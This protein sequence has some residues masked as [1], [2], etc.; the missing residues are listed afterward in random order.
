MTPDTGALVVSLD[1][2]LHWGVRDH[3]P[4]DGPYRANLLGARTAIPR[5]LDL[6]EE[7]GVSATWAVVGFL[8]AGSRADLER[9]R[10]RVLPR[11]ADRALDPYDEAVGEGEADDP[12]HYAP[13]LVAAI[14]ERP[15]QEIGTHSYSHYYCAEPGQGREA[16]ADD[17]RS[18]VA[19]A[20]RAGVELRSIVFPRNQVNPA[21][22]G[23][24][25]DAG[26]HCYR[27]TGP[28]ALAGAGSGARGRRLL[29][30]YLG[31]DA[32]AVPWESVRQPN[33]LH[34][35]AASLFLRPWTP[36]WRRFDRLRRDRV[37]RGLRE[38]ASSGQIF[39]LWWHPHNFGA[40]PDQNLAFLREVL[41]AFAA[42]RDRGAL[43]SLSMRGVAGELGAG[44]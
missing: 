22:A 36:R 2:E 19:I 6:F 21:Y 40:H 32:R 10:P 29:D 43:R 5:L 44:H 42:Y 9:H 31:R 3:E 11:Y 7:Y 4:V 13:S 1:F 26:L 30:A 25:V 28:A 39:H 34:D 15:G 8:F 16:F 12:L 35:V 20:G 24:L 17:L 14:R 23:V 38:A 33:G 27:G 41:E 18:A 37:V